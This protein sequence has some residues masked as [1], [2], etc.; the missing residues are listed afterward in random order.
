MQSTQ[1]TLTENMR[2]QAVELLNRHLAAAM[3]LRD[4]L[5]QAHGNVRG[6]TFIAVHELFDRIAGE[7]ES[8]S[9]LI[10]ER[11]AGLGGVLGGAVQVAGERSFLIP[12]LL[13][14]ADESEYIFAVAASLSAFGQSARDAI[15][16]S[17]TIGDADTA[18]LFSEI[19]R[20]IDLQLWLVESRLAPK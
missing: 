8:Y 1:S 9:N 13:H 14:I 2:S 3:D 10:A 19:S 6:P 5:K 4:Q 18:D 16:Q 12:Y 11:T 17:E 7:A 20:R 15:G